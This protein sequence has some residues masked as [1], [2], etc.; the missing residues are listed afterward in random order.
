MQ[1]LWL[2]RPCYK[3]KLVKRGKVLALCHLSIQF[4]MITFSKES[5]NG[6]LKTLPFLILV[7]RVEK[8]KLLFDNIFPNLSIILNADANE[9]VFRQSTESEVICNSV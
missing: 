8:Y 2:P 5:F 9:N 1:R 7:I 4:Y 6:N 3:N